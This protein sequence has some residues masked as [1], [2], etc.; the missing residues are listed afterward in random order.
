MLLRN[1]NTGAFEVYDISNNAITSSAAMGTVGLEWQGGGIA[2]D[3]PAASSAASTALLVQAMAGF[4]S[5]GAAIDQGPITQASQEGI[6]QPSL[7]AA[8]S[9]QHGA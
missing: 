5:D 6:S 2:A 7:F 4:P 8:P 3:P 9:L 1:S